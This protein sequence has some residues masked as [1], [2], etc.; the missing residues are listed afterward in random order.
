VIENKYLKDELDSEK[1]RERATFRAQ[2]QLLD[3][4]RLK[5]WELLWEGR[6]VSGLWR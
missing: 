4:L 3:R 2:N 6:C 1:W 5:G